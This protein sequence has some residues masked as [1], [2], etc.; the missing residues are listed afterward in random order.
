MKPTKPIAATYGR[1]S[2]PG[3]VDNF[4]LSSQ[5]RAMLALAAEKGYR[6]PREFEFVD[7][8]CLGGEMDRPAFMRLREA[9]RA[10]L[11]KAVL[12]YDL[13]RFVRGLALQMLVMEE[14]EKFGV[15]LELVT[16]PAEPTA[17]GRMF[18]QMRGV[19]SEYEKHKIRE[20]T[21]RG[22]VEKARLGLVN[23]GM[24]SYG[25]KYVGR[26]AGGRG[27]LV[28]VPERAEVVRRIF[29]W[30]EQGMGLRDIV[31]QLAAEGTAPL[32]AKRWDKRTISQILRNRVYIGESAYNRRCAAEPQKRRKP[33]P[34]GKS[35]KTSHRF[36]PEAEWIPVRVPRI[37]SDAQFA[38]VQAQLDKNRDRKGGRPSNRYSLSG[39]VECAACHRAVIGFPNRN[40]PYYRCG[41]IDRHTYHRNCPARSARVE[42]L[43]REVLSWL[44]RYKGPVALAAALAAD[45]QRAR[46]HAVNAK[47]EQKAL[48]ANIER[49]KAREQKAAKLLLDS[50]IADA[51]IMFREEL[52]EAQAQRRELERRLYTLAPVAQPSDTD[53]KRMAHLLVDGFDKLEERELFQ[54]FVKRVYLGMDGEIEDVEFTIPG[55]WEL[56]PPNDEPGGVHA[57]REYRQPDAHPRGGAAERDRGARRARCGPEPD[58]APTTHRKRAAGRRRRGT[59]RAVRLVGCALDAIVRRRQRAAPRRDFHRSARAAVHAAALARLRHRLR[60]G[61]GAACF[62]AC[63]E[64]RAG[65]RVARIVGRLA[66]G[67]RQ[68]PAPPAGGGRAGAF[69]GAAH[70]GGTAHPELHSSQPGFAG[71]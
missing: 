9:V 33:A 10:G 62:A 30:A 52:K 71:L 47:A 27:E 38:R 12:C 61:A 69:G 5:R 32:R 44:A 46:H 8:G 19:F 56:G 20:R 28:I 68:S 11:V 18:L 51:H 57:Y 6:V 65:R 55:G 23:G 26:A 40:R 63:L 54:R 29:R 43:E 16:T 7:E 15:A 50:D 70:R 37:I 67:A 25:Y 2:L 4:S 64:R 3:Q 1:V 17:E 60:P 58:C 35:K 39:L 59:R 21:T 42:K 34:A 53:I 48:R 41:N 14:L 45:A 36:R 49:L 24:T 13:D 22:R 66:L 31:L